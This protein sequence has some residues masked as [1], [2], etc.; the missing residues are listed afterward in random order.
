[1]SGEGDSGDWYYCLK[2]QRVEQ[3]MQCPAKNRLGPYASRGEAEQ[4]L[5]RVAE[6]NKDWD[7]DPRWS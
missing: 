3:G 4:A 1:M 5:D 7:E 6:R 2:H